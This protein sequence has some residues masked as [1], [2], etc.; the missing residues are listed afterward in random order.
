MSLTA[1]K[2][3]RIGARKKPKQIHPRDRKHQVASGISE[4]GHITKLLLDSPLKR[5]AYRPLCVPA[6]ELARIHVLDH[7]LAQRV[8]RALRSKSLPCKK[9]A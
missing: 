3:D 7:E 2:F 5:G 8:G 6:P 4:S 1:V 9:A